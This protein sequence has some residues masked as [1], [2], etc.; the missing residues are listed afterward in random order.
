MP[1][2]KAAQPKKAP[3]KKAQGKKVKEKEKDK[4]VEKLGV[5]VRQLNFDGM[6]KEA[7]TELFAKSCGKVSEIRL[8]GDKYVLVFFENSTGAK[9]CLEL[10]GKIV[11]GCKIL[12]E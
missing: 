3:A 2:K 4:A 11:K 12:C 8:R 7:L 9:K 5:Y 6:C 10:S 1:P